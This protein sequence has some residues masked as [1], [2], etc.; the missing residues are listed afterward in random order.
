MDSPSRSRFSRLG[1]GLKSGNNLV[2]R[3]IQFLTA[4]FMQGRVRCAL[5]IWLI[6][7]GKIPVQ[8]RIPTRMVRRTLALCSKNV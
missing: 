2:V 4:G 1:Q 5:L 6:L 3:A 8:L 7:L